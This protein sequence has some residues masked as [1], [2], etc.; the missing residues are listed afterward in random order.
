MNIYLLFFIIT[1]C[2]L[3]LLILATF[4]SRKALEKEKSR[5]RLR[6]MKPREI[7]EEIIKISMNKRSNIRE[8][9]YD[10]FRLEEFQQKNN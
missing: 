3:L 8:K 5:E 7:Y 4:L 9:A 6:N 1:I 2:L 10:T